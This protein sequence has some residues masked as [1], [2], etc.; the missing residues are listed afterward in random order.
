MTDRFARA[1]KLAVG[2]QYGVPAV[3][4]AAG[5][6]PS[7]VIPERTE[8]MAGKKAEAD[9]LYGY[10]DGRPGQ[11]RVVKGD[12]IPDGMVTIKSGRKPVPKSERKTAVTGPSET[13]EA[14]A[15]SD[16]G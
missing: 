10:E 16:K 13:P 6:V 7:V 12:P 3:N 4:P 2:R 15:K 9:G 14:P 11:F 5:S 1:D 8:S